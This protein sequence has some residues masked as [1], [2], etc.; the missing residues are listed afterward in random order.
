MATD[1][2]TL[3]AQAKCFDCFSGSIYML[4]LIKLELLIQLMASIG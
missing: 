3:M 1:P 2:Q 4:E